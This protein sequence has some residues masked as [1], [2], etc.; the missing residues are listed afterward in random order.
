MDKLLPLVQEQLA[1]VESLGQH[2][3]ETAQM[4]FAFLQ[5]L[6]GTADEDLGRRDVQ[7]GVIFDL[8]GVTE[9]KGSKR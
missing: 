6:Q 9:V 7:L 8:P 4:L 2:V 3:I 1:R 5:A